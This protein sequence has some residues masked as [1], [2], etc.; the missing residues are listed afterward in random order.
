MFQSLFKKKPLIGK[1]SAKY[2]LIVFL[3]FLQNIVQGEEYH[4]RA[5]LVDNLYS[6][7]TNE[8]EKQSFLK[9][10]SNHQFTEL[11]FYTGGPVDTR[12]IP[13]KMPEFDDL[14][15]K[16]QSVG[17]TR[18]QIAVGSVAEMDRVM[19][20]I[21]TYQARVNGFWLEFEWW[22]NSPRNFASAKS[23]ITYIRAN[24]EGRSIGAYI[25]WVT[26]EEMTDLTRMV[27]FIYIH[28]YVPNGKR[29]YSKVK[30]RLNMIQVAKPIR[31][32]RI[33]P[34]FSAEWL[35]PE[36]CNQGP[37]NPSF[38]DQMCFM[39]PWLKD[40]G[41]VIGAENAF[42][43]ENALDRRSSTSWRN[44]ASIRGFYYFAYTHLAKAL[45]N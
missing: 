23:L 34:I 31:K 15:R 9:F 14:I 10:I 39:G 33:F 26:Q 27:D 3:F 30:D 1:R 17:V 16:V 40:N 25:G 22:N 29:T 42:N 37:S 11:T 18:I 41:G 7:V 4:M 2:I 19:M 21:K 28:S 12:V 20:F 5:L 36:I 32:A 45:Q 35:P 38:Y 44:Y 13:L 8:E 24:G 43:A 6:I